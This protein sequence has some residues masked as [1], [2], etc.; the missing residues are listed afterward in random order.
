M[1]TFFFL[2]LSINKWLSDIS[3]L[4]KTSYDEKSGRVLRFDG[5][6]I[7]SLHPEHLASL[8][9]LFEEWYKKGE[10]N[11]KLGRSSPVGNFLFNQLE[12]SSYWAGKK[13]YSKSKQESILNLW[14][15]VEEEKEVHGR[16]VSEYLKNSYFKKKDLSAVENSLT[17]A[18]YNIFDHAKANGNA[19]TMLDFDQQDGVLHVAVCDFGIGICQSVRNFLGTDISDTDALSKAVEANFTVKSASYNAGQGL[20]NIIDSCTE[21]D[22]VC[23]ISNSASLT[24]KGET[25]S[26]EKLPFDFGGTLLF[27]SMSLSHFDDEEVL[28]EFKW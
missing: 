11:L 9:C 8:A 13:N 14:R 10:I 2:D 28:S 24:I 26:V 21:D 15:I 16:R 5:L 7:D 3:D 23:I 27:Y 22:R 12:I 6:R 4:R 17:E 20:Q 1:D 19:F 18:Y 25:R